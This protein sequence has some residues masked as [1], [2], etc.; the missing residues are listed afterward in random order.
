MK[1]NQNPK[2]ADRVINYIKENGSITQYQA[3]FDIGVMRLASRI[4]ELKK[5]GYSFDS[6]MVT[7]KNRFDEVCHVKQY[8][9][10]E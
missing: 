3:L 5:K 2:Q 1:N 6:K 8:S 7:V 9:L 10:S 4:S